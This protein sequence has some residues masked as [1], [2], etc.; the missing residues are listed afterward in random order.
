M[1]ITETKGNNCLSRID[2]IRPTEVYHRYLNVTPD[3]NFVYNISEFPLAIERNGCVIARV[4]PRYDDEGRLYFSC[5]VYTGEKI[6]LTYAVHEDILQETAISSEYMWGFAPEALFLI[7]CGNRTLFLKEKAPLEIESYRRFAPNLICNYGT[8]EIYCH[9]GKGGILNSALVAIGMREGEAHLK[10]SNNDLKHQDKHRIIPLSERMA[11]FLNAVTK[12][13]AESNQEL[14]AMARAA[15]AAS[16]A[17]SQFLSNMSHEIRTPIN[18]VLGMDEMILRETREEHIREYAEN[19]RTAGNTLLSLINDI[20]D[21]SKIEAG[22]LEIIPVEYSV[23]SFL[24]DLANMIRQRAENKG[25]EFYVESDEDMPSVL[26]GDEIRLRQVVTN[27]LTNAVKYTEKG[28]VTLRLTW[29][30]SPASPN[31]I[32]LRVEVQ[33]TGI[34]IKEED[35]EKLFHAFERIEEERNRT[36]EG[37]GLGMN[38]AQR[39]LELMDSQLEVKSIYGKG[40]LFAFTISQQVLNWTPMGNYEAAYRQHLQQQRHYQESFVAPEA[41]ILIV[42]DTAM[43]LSVAK[44]LLKQTQIVVDTALSGYECLNKVQKE[45]Y[46]IILLDHRMPGMDGMETLAGIKEL[47]VKNTF[48]NRQT[49]IIALTANAISGARE[50]YITAGFDDY[51]AKPID[52]HQLESLLQNYLP[53]EKIRPAGSIQLP[54]A[55]A[56][57]PGWLNQVSGLDLQ[58]GLQHCGS[59]SDYLDALTVFAQSIDSGAT[60]IQ[61]FY[62][63]K[64]WDN[65]TTKVHALKSTARVIGA[66]ELSEKARRL[67]DAGNNGYCDEICTNTGALLALYRRFEQELAPLLPQEKTDSEKAPISAAE[68]TEAWEALSEIVMSFDYDSLRYILDELSGFQLS[69][70]D[71]EKLAAAK[72][73]AAL[74]DWDAL[75]KILQT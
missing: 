12:E 73:A 27:I 70:A 2:N 46:D 1:T 21:F 33:D 43:N 40:S 63:L 30:G 35:I 19:I 49:P 10:P 7:A 53:A 18:A 62:D 42:D 15:E 68:L 8:S 74:P 36:I 9:Q 25:L 72:K 17:K 4:P 29:T 20:L 59:A 37:T 66:G 34:G 65:Y 57:L 16:L 13:L 32:R 44:G 56:D 60:E 5:D 50:E 61:R 11:T 48:P 52:S 22:K 6:R 38:I 26:K 64:D 51:L 45:H 39:L 67:E 58:A 31:E 14:R 28:H 71:A 3:E 47:A 55:D 75:Q 24:N 69:G 54:K 23:S 41:N